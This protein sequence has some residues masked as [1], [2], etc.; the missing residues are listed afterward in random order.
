MHVCFH[1]PHER[2]A[3]PPQL[4]KQYLNRSIYEDQAQYYANVANMDA[5]VGRLMKT[6]EEQQLSENT[7]VFFTSDNG[8]ETLNRYGK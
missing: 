1:E 3:S 8:P 2:V 4:V 6:L 5:A 7:F